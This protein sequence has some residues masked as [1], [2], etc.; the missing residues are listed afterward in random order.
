MTAKS[1]A[2]PSESPIARPMR[3]AFESLVS[4][5]SRGTT[6]AVRSYAYAHYAVLSLT[7]PI[8]ISAVAAQA[9]KTCYRIFH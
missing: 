4:P 5:G 2:R 1:P 3:R 9:S 7:E 8:F 6:Q